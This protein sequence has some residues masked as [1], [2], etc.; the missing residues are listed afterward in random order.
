MAD[1]DR[2]LPIM[3]QA[4]WVL[5]HLFRVGS[6]SPASTWIMS[7]KLGL[8]I[9]MRHCA[10]NS[11]WQYNGSLS[12]KSRPW[13]SSLRGPANRF[14]SRSFELLTFGLTDMKLTCA[15]TNLGPGVGPPTPDGGCL[16]IDRFDEF[17]DLDQTE[18]VLADSHL[19]LA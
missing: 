3:E 2:S 16:A 5:A 18:I 14:A 10:R 4:D 7:L 13:L 9:S 12:T 17:V 11:G 1:L 19:I 6:S 15:W 8:T